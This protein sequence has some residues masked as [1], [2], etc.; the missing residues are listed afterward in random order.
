MIAYICTTQP[1]QNDCALN[2]DGHSIYKLSF[3]IPKIHLEWID[4]VATSLFEY[5]EGMQHGTPGKGI[6]SLHFHH[7]VANQI[8]SVDNTFS[9]DVKMGRGSQARAIQEAVLDWLKTSAESNADA[10]G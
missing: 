4:D 7:W 2:G 5:H 8:K 10:E 6:D 3:Y 9:Y 1:G